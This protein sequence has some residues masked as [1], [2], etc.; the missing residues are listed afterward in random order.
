MPASLVLRSLPRPVTL[1]VPLAALAVLWAAPAPAPA[2]ALAGDCAT[3][4]SWKADRADLANAVIK[5]VNQHRASLGLHTL[6]V[7]PALTRSAVWKARHMA[8]YRYMAHDDPAPPVARSAGQRIAACGYASSWG[9][10]IA[11]GFPTAASVVAAWLGSPG[12]RANIENP[13]Y[14]V[15]G[16]GAAAAAGGIVLWAQDFGTTPE[17][18]STLAGGGGTTGPRAIVLRNL[19]LAPHRPHA[20]GRLSAHVGAVGAPSMKPLAHATVACHGT[21]AGRTLPVVSHGFADGVAAC[22]WRVAGT[23]LVTARIVVSS[24]GHA[25]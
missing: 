10:N 19:R 13:S 9:E 7:S 2:T 25:A 4:S 21:A 23:A 1:V 8:T 11:E 6:A 12:H 16:S 14:R 22:T 18:G 15:T 5:L 24:G 20:G 3:P 17:A